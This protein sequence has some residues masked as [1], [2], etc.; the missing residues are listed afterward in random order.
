MSMS[1]RGMVEFL[2]PG[3]STW[4]A[5]AR[6][7]FYGDAN[8][9]AVLAFPWGRWSKKDDLPKPVVKAKGLPKDLS[10]TTIHETHWIVVPPG[11]E[12]DELRLCTAK[13]ARGWKR[14]PLK[15]YALNPTE[16]CC[17]TWLTTQEMSLAC[18][19][20]RTFRQSGY[21]SPE[22]EGCLAMM[23]AIEDHGPVL[24]GGGSKARAVFWF[25]R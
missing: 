19:A 12:R 5:A 1:G 25:Q 20:Y 9:F 13:E 7:F 14:G 23:R 10:V 6:L 3:S 17:T 16:W 11:E 24:G 15:S 21:G 22:L 8:A 2:N 18:A 4:W